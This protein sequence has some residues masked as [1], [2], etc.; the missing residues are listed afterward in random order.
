MHGKKLF[1][2][3]FFQV[4]V[5]ISNHRIAF[6]VWDTSPCR[7]HKPWFSWVSNQRTPFRW[8]EQRGQRW[9][10]RSLVTPWHRDQPPS[11]TLHRASVEQ[12]CFCHGPICAA[13]SRMLP[14]SKLIQ[15]WNYLATRD[16]LA[17]WSELKNNLLWPSTEILLLNPLWNLN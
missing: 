11:K 6:A 3:I 5:M 12:K 15:R 2:M 7:D 17:S 14:L 13:R 8:V 1:C 4:Q 9:P 16:T 10:L